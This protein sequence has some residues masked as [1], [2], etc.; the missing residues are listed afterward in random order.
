MTSLNIQKLNIWE[1]VY[2]HINIERCNVK[3]AG[4]KD[5]IHAAKLSKTLKKIWMSIDY[6]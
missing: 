4:M 5:V 6:K 3:E 1:S 2:N